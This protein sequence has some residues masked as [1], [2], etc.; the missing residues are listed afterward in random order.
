MKKINLTYIVVSIINRWNSAII[1]LD[2]DQYFT[3]FFLISPDF[4][5]VF[6]PI[7]SILCKVDPYR[8]DE[9]GNR[10]AS[11]FHSVRDIFCLI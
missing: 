2:S 10:T 5:P 6:P 1:P 11:N 4:Y 9:Y 3:G 7:F 8:K